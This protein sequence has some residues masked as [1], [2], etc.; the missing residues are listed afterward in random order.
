MNKTMITLLAGVA[1]G[2]LVAPDKG[3]ETFKRFTN[4]LKGLKDQASKEAENLYDTGKVGLEKGKSK[5][6]SAGRELK[7]QIIS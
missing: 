4:G 7:T 3:S 5:L 6:S 2:L 1:I